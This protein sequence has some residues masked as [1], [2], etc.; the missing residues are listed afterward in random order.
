MGDGD[1]RPASGD[2]IEGRLDDL[3]ASD[4]DGTCSFVEDQES[5]TLDNTSRDRQSLSL[6]ATECD[7]SITD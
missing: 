3:L 4:I 6:P 2:S 1:R 7:P 5:G